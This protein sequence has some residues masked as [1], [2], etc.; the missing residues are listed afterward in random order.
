MNVQVSNALGEIH[1]QT[2]IAVQEEISDLKLNLTEGSRTVLSPGT[3]VE[4]T[5][6]VRTGSDL[7]FSW[8]FNDSET[9]GT[10]S[11]HQNGR[12]STASHI[13][14]E[15]GEACASNITF[16]MLQNCS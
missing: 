3:E 6:S 16:H 5:A 7:D 2:I 13:Y 8:N 15:T 11:I 12:L 10:T 4:L 14:L 1:T 9:A